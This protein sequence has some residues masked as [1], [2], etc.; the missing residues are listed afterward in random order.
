MNT[1]L[2]APKEIRDLFADLMDREITLTTT[3][4]LAP[5]PAVPASVGVLVDDSLEITALVVADLP[6]S[7]YAGAALGLVPLPAAEAAIEAGQL[8]DVLVENYYEVV[9][10]ISSL[11]NAPGAR[12]VRLHALHP[13]GGDL[14]PN[15]R[16]R[17]LT[18]GRRE[19]VELSIAGYGAGRLSLVLC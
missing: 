5:G 1:H 10:I 8:D 9:N 4:P 19:D 6:L 14:D 11:F 12:H 13:A 2:P 7:A 15:L 18:L 16:V 3:A 17:A